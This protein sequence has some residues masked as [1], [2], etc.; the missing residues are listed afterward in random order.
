MCCREQLRSVTTFLLSFFYFV[1]VS[2]LF[3]Q[4]KKL[5]QRLLSAAHAYYAR[6]LLGLRFNT[7]PSCRGFVVLSK[8]FVVRLHRVVFPHYWRGG[9]GGIYPRLVLRDSQPI[10]GVRHQLIIHLR[11][12]ASYRLEI[13]RT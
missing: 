1:H 11:C 5:R 6:L 10:T 12:E 7:P 3:T 13:T 2:F 8:A 9:S 4:K